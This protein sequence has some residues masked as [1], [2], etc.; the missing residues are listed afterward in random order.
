MIS[1]SDV[2]QLLPP[3]GFL[4]DYVDDYGKSMTDGPLAYHLGTA[5]SL[6]AITAPTDYHFP[7]GGPLYTNI[8]FLFVGPSSFGRKTECIKIGENLLRKAGGQD[9]VAEEPGSDE[10]LRDG[11]LDKPKQLLSFREFGQFLAKADN[12]FL[13]PVKTRLNSCFDN[14]PVSRSLS[15]KSKEPPKVEYNPRVSLL[16][17]SAPGYLERHTEPVDWTE[18]FLARFLT[19]HAKPEREMAVRPYTTPTIEATLVAG[20]QRR[21]QLM[22]HEVTSC[23]GFDAAAELLWREWFAT[24]RVRA[25]GHRE[26]AAAAARAPTMALKICALLG[27]DNGAA[28]ANAPWL[29]DVSMLQYAIRILELHLKSVED[30]GDNLVTSRDM[31]DRRKVLRELDEPLPLGGQGGLLSKA[32][33]LK[34]RCVQVLESLIEEGAVSAAGAGVTGQLFQATAALNKAAEEGAQPG[35]HL[36]LVP[37]ATGS[38]DY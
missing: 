3:S 29:V 30:L 33:L 22:E 5:L 31:Q 38:D 25:N 9:L 10:G 27:L 19:F 15:R 13:T 28:Y 18:G 4:R 26:T 34:G 12:S 32:K 24:I 6:L 17:G 35:G 8:F 36:R 7:F 16:A 37:P 20:L 11:I 21:L 2:T 1:E 14:S 23:S